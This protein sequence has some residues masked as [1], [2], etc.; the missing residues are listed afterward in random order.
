VRDH[1]RFVVDV[2]VVTA[3]VDEDPDVRGRCV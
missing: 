2:G 3:A 1:E